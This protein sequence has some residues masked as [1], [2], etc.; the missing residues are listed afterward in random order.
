MNSFRA[1]D[2]EYERLGQPAHHDGCPSKAAIRVNRRTFID[3]GGSIRS[4]ICRFAM[5]QGANA[6]ACWVG[7]ELCL[8]A[9]T[10]RRKAITKLGAGLFAAAAQRYSLDFF[11][12]NHV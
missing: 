5:Y 8:I 3:Q 10:N 12:Q 4:R 11:L 1:A 6:A 9:K 7:I 2:S